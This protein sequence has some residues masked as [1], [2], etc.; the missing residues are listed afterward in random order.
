MFV[1]Q[2]TDKVMVPLNYGLREATGRLEIV[3]SP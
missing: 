2:K 1:D 3:N